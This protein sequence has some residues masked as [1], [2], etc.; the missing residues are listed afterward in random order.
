MEHNS[1]YPEYPE[2]KHH[3]KHSAGNETRRHNEEMAEELAVPAPRSGG[4]VRVLQEDAAEKTTDAAR[5]TGWAALVL[6]ILSWIVWPVLLGITAAVVGFI[7]FRQG[8][9][10]LGIWSMTLGLIAAAAYL[11]LIPFYYAVT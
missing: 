1:D 10:G 4:R 3:S 7:A 9:R 11:V 5:A 2:Y 6:A 8:S